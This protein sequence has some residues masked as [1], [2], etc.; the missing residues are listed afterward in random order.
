[1]AIPFGI[2]MRLL[3][4]YCL[5]AGS[6]PTYSPSPPCTLGQS[7]VS[8]LALVDV[9]AD[10]LRGEMLDLQQGQAFMKRVTIRAST[11][12]APQGSHWSLKTCKVLEF[13]LYRPGH[14]WNLSDG[15]LEILETPCF[16]VL[17]VN[18]RLKTSWVFA[19]KVQNGY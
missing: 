8:E 4:V 5:I 1:M 3:L 14:I 2:L 13:R 10:K 11:G 7:G 12:K 16:G 15:S 17:E 6:V 19:L 9:A 18:K